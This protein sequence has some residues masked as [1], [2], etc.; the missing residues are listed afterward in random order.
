MWKKVTR[1]KVKILISLEILSILFAGCFLMD[2]EDEE[3]KS[4]DIFIQETVD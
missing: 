4:D 2:S 3:E 1:N